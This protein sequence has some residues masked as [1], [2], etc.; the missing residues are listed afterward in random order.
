MKITYV[1][2]AEIKEIKYLQKRFLGLWEFRKRRL[3]FVTL[4]TL[5]IRCNKKKSIIFVIDGFSNLDVKNG[6]QQ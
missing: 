5:H 6:H 1:N 2:N 4:H 3:C